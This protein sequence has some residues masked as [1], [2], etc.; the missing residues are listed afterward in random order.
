M[1][2]VL[3]RREFMGGTIG[4]GGDVFFGFFWRGSSGTF[5]SLDPL[6]ISARPAPASAAEYSTAADPDAVKG[7]VQWRLKQHQRW[8]GRRGQRAVDDSPNWRASL[9]YS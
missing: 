9:V 6:P 8:R 4:G 2:P 5:V 7:P 3:F 1:T